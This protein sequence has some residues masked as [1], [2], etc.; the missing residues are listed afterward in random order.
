MNWKCRI[1]LH[2]W[3]EEEYVHHITQGSQVRYCERCDK[4]QELITSLF[5]NF[6]YDA[7]R[8]LCKVFHTVIIWKRGK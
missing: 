6:Y 8:S 5:G 7:M 2:K 1:G 3:I 4:T